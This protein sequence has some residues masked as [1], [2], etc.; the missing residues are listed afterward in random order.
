MVK[1]HFVWCVRNWI[2][3]LVIGS[4]DIAFFPP[5]IVFMP[6]CGRS[7]ILGTVI[8]LHPIV[9]EVKSSVLPYPDTPLW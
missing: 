3:K 9:V 7:E 5:E 8:S 2:G 4:L 6:H 1:V